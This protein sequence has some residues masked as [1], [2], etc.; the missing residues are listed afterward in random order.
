MSDLTVREAA[1]ELS[2]SP[3]TVRALIRARELRAFKLR[4]DTGAWRIRPEALDE[5]RANQEARRAD[6]WVR[7]RDRRG[8]GAA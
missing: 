2:T 4:G 7:T 8:K 5:Y 3:Y 1:A 6:P